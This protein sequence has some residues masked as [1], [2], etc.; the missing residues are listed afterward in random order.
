[1]TLATRNN[2]IIV[3]DG[4]IA[5]NCGC[6]GG[7]CVCDATSVKVSVSSGN[8]LRH[9]LLSNGARVSLAYIAAPSSGVHV[10]RKESTGPQ[11]GFWESK[12]VSDNVPSPGNGRITAVVFRPPFAPVRV[13][14]GIPVWYWRSVDIRPEGTFKSLNEMITDS[15]GGRTALQGYG[16]LVVELVC[17]SQ[18]GT[19]RI[20]SYFPGG[21]LGGGWSPVGSQ[22]PFTACDFTDVNG[23]LGFSEWWEGEAL[24]KGTDRLISQGV[25]IVSDTRTG[26]NVVTLNEVTLTCC[27]DEGACCEGTT[28]SVKPQCQCQCATG[29]CC[30]PDTATVGG[31]TGQVCRGGTKQE[32]DQRGGTWTCG[33]SCSAEEKSGIALC[34]SAMLANPNLPVFKGVGTTCATG[35]CA[36]SGLCDCAAGAAPDAFLVKITNAALQLSRGNTSDFF[37]DAMRTGGSCESDSAVIAWLNS[38]AVPVTL[39]SA[40][41]GSVVY[42]GSVTTQGPFSSVRVGCRVTVP[43]GGAMDVHFYWCPDSASASTCMSFVDRQVSIQMPAAGFCAFQS[44]SMSVQTLFSQYPAT[45]NTSALDINGIGVWTC[46]GTI[47]SALAAARFFNGTVTVQRNPLP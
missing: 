37:Y 34:S 3:K 7:L 4:Q 22:V 19:S 31:V 26:D 32:C 47:P 28:C 10:L 33:Y 13:T 25:S 17:D 9:M 23:V 29:K 8:F 1:M 36:A 27:E 44:Q 42:S 12:W 39:L 14:V 46:R 35:V 45:Q 24:L 16:T 43:C 30:G 21:G 40:V 5:E 38:I 11:V 41:Q 6:C 2:A 18:T 15:E 20:F